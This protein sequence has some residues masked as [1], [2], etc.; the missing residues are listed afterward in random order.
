VEGSERANLV[1]ATSAVK[2]AAYYEQLFQQA[3]LRERDRIM[4]ETPNFAF[5][6]GG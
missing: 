1:P 6:Q 3:I 4:D 5:W 2:T